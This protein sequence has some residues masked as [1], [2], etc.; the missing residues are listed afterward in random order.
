ME[1]RQ[2]AAID[3]A[4]I[5]AYFVVVTGIGLHFVRRA[6]DATSYFLAGRHAGWI[7]IGGALFAA[8]ISSEHFVGLAGDGYTSGL[9]VAQFELFAAV[10]C[11]ALGWVFIPFYIRAGVFTMPEFLE[12]RY[13]P[14]CR[15]YLTVISL[16]SYV[17]TKISVTLYAGSLFLNMLFGWDLYTSSLIMVVATGLYTVAGGLAA[18]IY[19]EL[20]QAFVLVAGAAMLTWI[21]LDRAGGLSAV[22]DAIPKDHWSMLKPIDHPAYPWPGMIFGLPILGIWYWC[23]DQYIV[24]RALGARNVDHARGG[25]LLAGFLKLLPMFLLVLPGMIALKLFPDVANGES[26]RVYPMLTTL[27]PAGVKGLVI[28][29]LFAAMMSSLA[30]CFNSCG[31]LFTMDLYKPRRPQ[32]TERELVFVGRAVT[33]VMVAIGIAYVPMMEHLGGSDLYQYLQKIQAYISPPIAAVFLLGVFFKRLNG[34]GA[35]ASL[36]AGFVLGVARLTLEFG[37][38]AAG[39]R[40][41]PIAPLVEMNFLH[42]AICLF[43]VCVG[44]LV[45]V[46]LATPAAPA[47]QL[48]GLTFATTAKEAR[49]VEIAAGTRRGRRATMA[50]TW[51]LIA[52]LLALWAIFYVI[53]PL[54][55]AS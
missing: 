22:I 51:I 26:N 19:T 48:A 46:S 29:G 2:L 36:Y 32:A 17:L 55:A 11:L 4:L 50:A 23:T 40:L 49:A 28:A 54:R 34:R 21:G 5:G 53:I 1:T 16:V 6:K 18:V 38:N 39:W 20:I 33:V 52:I 44:V 7:A 31:T 24:Q 45:A 25:A 42:F 8:N 41:G 13:N 12:R 9:A 27:L 30:A 37:S 10:A 47:A 14:A 35:L 43:A 3:W 15:R